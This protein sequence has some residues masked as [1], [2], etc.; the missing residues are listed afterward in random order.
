MQPMAGETQEGLRQRVGGHRTLVTRRGRSFCCPAANPRTT[1]GKAE[2]WML[3]R[4]E[5]TQPVFRYR[6]DVV[7]AAG[8]VNKGQWNYMFDFGSLDFWFLKD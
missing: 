3:L 4:E 2:A 7:P 1:E 8:D 5:L 6:R